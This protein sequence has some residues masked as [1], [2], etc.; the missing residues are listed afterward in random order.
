MVSSDTFGKMCETTPMQM[1]WRKLPFFSRRHQT[2]LFLTSQ[3]TLTRM[4]LSLGISQYNPIQSAIS[5]NL[6]GQIFQTE[7]DYIV[8]CPQCMCTSLVL[9][10][11]ITVS[12]HMPF[13][14]RNSYYLRVSSSSILPL[15]VGLYLR[16]TCPRLMGYTYSIGLSGQRAC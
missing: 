11:Y 3:A 7:L 12:S 10:A 15:Y 13:F 4:L 1:N 8:K 14:P 2:A 9:R 6:I 5:Q 16:C